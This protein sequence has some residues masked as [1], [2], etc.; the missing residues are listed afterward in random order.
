MTPDLP[1]ESDTAGLPEY[2][3]ASLDAIG[4]REDLVV[5]GQSLG[6]LMSAPHWVCDTAS[7]ASNSSVL[8][9]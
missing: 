1:C 2:T 8:S 4:E 6:A 5:V 3:A 9:L 7:F